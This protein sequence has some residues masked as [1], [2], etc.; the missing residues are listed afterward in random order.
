METKIGKFIENCDVC[1]IENNSQSFKILKENLV[2]PL[3]IIP[4]DNIR[5]FTSSDNFLIVDSSWENCIF[6]FTS[7]YNLNQVNSL[8]NWV[9]DDP[10]RRI[11]TFS[12]CADRVDEE[13]PVINFTSIVSLDGFSGFWS[14]TYSGSFFASWTDQGIMNKTQVI[15]KLIDEVEDQR[16]GIITL[17]DDNIKIYTNGTYSNYV[18]GPGSYIISFDIQDRAKNSVPEDLEINVLVTL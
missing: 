16:D 10:S 3:M 1:R 8:L 2:D 5:N 15:E 18:T 17:R 7:S 6:S 9:K 13:A 12:T 14:S 4:I 11:G